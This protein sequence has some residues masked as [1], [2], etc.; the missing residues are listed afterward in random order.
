[1]LLDRGGDIR[2]QFVTLR[3]ASEKVG[4]PWE[5]ES[6]ND[7]NSAEQPFFPSE[8]TFFHWYLMVRT[9]A[10]NG[11]EHLHQWYRVDAA[12]LAPGSEPL[13][14][15]GAPSVMIMGIDMVNHSAQHVLQN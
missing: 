10:F 15:N 6:E 4:M 7:G 13:S 5:N 2:T 8:D 1:M 14:D 11:P 3:E 12:D 9:R